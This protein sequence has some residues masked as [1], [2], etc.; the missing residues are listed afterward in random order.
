MEIK[1]KPI[2]DKCIGDLVS[3]FKK[4]NIHY[5]DWDGELPNVVFFNDKKEVKMSH[6]FFY[7]HS[8]MCCANAKTSEKDDKGESKYRM[9]ILTDKDFYGDRVKAILQFHFRD[10]LAF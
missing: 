7:R 2:K 8:G 3:Y 6:E 1:D 9:V 10:Y 4:Y 5:K